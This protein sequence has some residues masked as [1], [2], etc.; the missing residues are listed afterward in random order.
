MNSIILGLWPLAGITSTPPLE[1]EAIQ[2]IL[3]AI[4]S[5]VERFDTAYSYGY[6]GE[7]DRLL[8]SAFEELPLETRAPLQIIGKVGQRWTED[9][10]RIIDCRPAQLV[11]DAEASLKRLGR[12]R[13]D[14][15]MLHAV[16]AKVDL[17]RS[18]AAIATLR[19]RGLA[20]RTGISNANIEEI[21][22]FA[23]A[24]PCD[25][26]Q[27]PLNLIQPQ[28]LVPLIEHADHKRIEVYC[29]WTLMKGILAGQIA[30]DHIF[31]QGDSRPNYDVYQGE[32]RRRA[33]DVVDRLAEMA[34]RL[35]TTVARLSIGWVLSQRGVSAAI[36]GAKSPNQIRETA[37]AKPLAADVLAEIDGILGGSPDRVR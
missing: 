34:I 25:A 14:L 32:Q 4:E 2:T 16:D 21:D 1:S 23:E 3:A 29:Y 17:G 20:I 5:G 18:A 12:E 7:S 33:H 26:I 8:R 27:C 31:G 22:R 30:R 15:L 10:R 24:C 35:E 19:E 6:E 11:A 13:F 9:R 28:T 36:V 37:D